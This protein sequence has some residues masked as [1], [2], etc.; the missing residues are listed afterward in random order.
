MSSGKSAKGPCACSRTFQHKRSSHEN[1]TN[2]R[3]NL[4]DIHAGS[5]GRGQS[6]QD[7]SN[8]TAVFD[9]SPTM[10]D[11]SMDVFQELVDDAVAWRKWCKLHPLI[12]EKMLREEA[13][14]LAEW[15]SKETKGSSLNERNK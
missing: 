13:K 12:K 9:G 11:V 14:E 2:L 15:R 4:H 8:R 10:S 3:F 7:G 1:A 5:L 6:V